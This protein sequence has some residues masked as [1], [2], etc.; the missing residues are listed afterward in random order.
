MQHETPVLEVNQNNNKPEPLLSQ[1]ISIIVTVISD[2]LHL[3]YLNPLLIGENFLWP[4]AVSG[5]VD[6][7]AALGKFRIIVG[8]PNLPTLVP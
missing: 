2:N 7:L 5:S 3:D 1:C 8:K 4:G 6:V